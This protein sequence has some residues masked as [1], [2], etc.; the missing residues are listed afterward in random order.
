MHSIFSP[1]KM[2]IY[3]NDT[4][5]R[6]ETESVLT[7]RQIQIR[8]L[9]KQKSIMLV[10]TPKGKFAVQILDSNKM[11]KYEIKKAKG[12]GIYDTYKTKNLLVRNNKINKSFTFTYIP[13]ISAK[14]LPGFESFPGLLTKYYVHT[15][16]GIYIYEL[17]KME[18]KQTPTLLYGVSSEYQVIKMDQFIQLFSE[19]EVEF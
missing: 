11:N 13:K 19:E 7:G 6:I 17:E 8:H 3:T 1:E 15:I 12:K 5:V 9:A 16:D 2:I 18:V 4:L 14:Y 10:E